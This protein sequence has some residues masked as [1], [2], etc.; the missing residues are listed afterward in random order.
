MEMHAMQG[1]QITHVLSTHRN[2]KDDT[3]V[4]MIS[5]AR[6]E[7]FMTLERAVLTFIESIVSVLPSPPR[8]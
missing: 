4:Q 2:E 8:E 1:D 5:A 7:Y 6:L 3:P